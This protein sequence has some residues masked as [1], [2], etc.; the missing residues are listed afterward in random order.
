MEK[1]LIL[2]GVNVD[3]QMYTLD[4][5]RLKVLKDYAK[6]VK[7]HRNEDVEVR[8]IFPVGDFNKVLYKWERGGP[9]IA[10]RADSGHECCDRRGQRG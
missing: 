4:N 1:W 7:K 5:R 9:H 8:I 2:E 3:G 6:F 10:I